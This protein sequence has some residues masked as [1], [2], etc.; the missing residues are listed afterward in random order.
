MGSSINNTIRKIT[1]SE[2]SKNRI[3]A[4]LEKIRKREKEGLANGTLVKVDCTKMYGGV[5]TFKIMKK[6]KAIKLGLYEEA[7]A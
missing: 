7:K 5:R 3:K 2:N 1:D 4:N 6:E